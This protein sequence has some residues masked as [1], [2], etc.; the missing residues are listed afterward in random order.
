MGAMKEF[1]Q[2]YSPS[3]EKTRETTTKLGSF[4]GDST[5]KTIS[6][7]HWII[8]SRGG[9]AQLSGL[10]MVPSQFLGPE[11]VECQIILNETIS[12]SKNNEIEIDI[13]EIEIGEDT[14]LQGIVY[15]PKGWDRKDNS[16][17]VVYHNPN[18]ITFPQYFEN[19]VLSWTPSKILEI[20][21]CPII[22]YDYRGTGMSQNNFT[23]GTLQFRPTY[24][25]IAKDGE[26]VLELAFDSFGEV[27]VWGSSLGG[28]VATVALDH[29][30]KE[31]P[32]LKDRVTLTNHD[33]FTTT[34][35]V[36]LPGWRIANWLG[37]AVGGNLDAE[38][39]MR[40]LIKKGIKI[41]VLFHTDDPVIPSGARMGESVY[42]DIQKSKNGKVFMSPK[43]GHA[44]LSSDMVAFL[45]KA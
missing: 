26:K 3:I 41:V 18:G 15:Y 25:T 16:R 40:N 39:P 29:C 24:A 4:L 34:S 14:S 28:G 42:G 11:L 7:I 6:K 2:S 23:T 32:Q 19:N 17:C 35:R 8:E 45:K 44:D 43:Y 9:L 5:R 30:I 38:T 36:V 10:M 37:W 20:E 21:K 1:W 33:S 31:Q 22:L 27:S 13:F 12:N